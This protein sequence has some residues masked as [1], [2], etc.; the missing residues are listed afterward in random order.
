M[1]PCFRLASFDLG[2]PAQRR[3]HLFDP[4]TEQAIM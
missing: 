4:E 1:A 2:G 3:L